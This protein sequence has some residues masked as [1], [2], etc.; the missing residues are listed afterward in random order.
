MAKNK[1]EKVRVHLWL[2]KAT[3]DELHVLYDEVPGFS[4]SIQIILDRVLR[5][6]RAKR[7]LRAD[8]AE[9]PE[10]IRLP[11]IPTKATP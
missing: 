4:A 3:V 11:D 6:I 1:P 9:C 2:N 10:S 5:D 7:E 8:T